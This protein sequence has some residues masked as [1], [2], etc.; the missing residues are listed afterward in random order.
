MKKKILFLFAVV[1]IMVSTAL[2]SCSS[3]NE[4]LINDY[5][6]VCKE[7]IS[8][9]QNNDATQ[10]MALKEQAENIEKKLQECDLTEEQQEEV[11]QIAGEL[12][13]QML[14]SLEQPDG[15]LLEF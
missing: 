4:K 11:Q 13:F 1:A 10:V 8:A 15:N 12:F 2:V 3:S 5:R 9:M 7:L 6:D 14:S